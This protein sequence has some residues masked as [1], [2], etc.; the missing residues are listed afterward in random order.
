MRFSRIHFFFISLFHNFHRR[1]YQPS[2]AYRTADRNEAS[3]LLEQPTEFLPNKP[4]EVVQVEVAWK[5]Q[6][7]HSDGT[8]L[9]TWLRI[10]SI[11]YK[12]RT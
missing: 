10:R 12:G 9:G 8:F 3:L 11:G 5:Q 4:V 1:L 7:L 6:S 2:S